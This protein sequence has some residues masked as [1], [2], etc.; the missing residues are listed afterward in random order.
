LRTGSQL[1]TWFPAYDTAFGK[2][3]PGL[4]Q[5]LAM[6]Q[7]FA[8]M[9]LRHIDMG[10]GE[11]DYK[12]SLKTRDLEVAE[13]RIA[14]MSPGAGLH[15]LARMPARKLRNVVLATPFLRERADRVLKTYAKL[16]G[17]RADG[18]TGGSTD[19]NTEGLTKK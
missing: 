17:G 13:G 16:T 1:C 19:K 11:K 2:Y 14:R 8:A 7:D 12:E 4:L 5:H 6:A 9:G 18:S 3:S 15:W 10:R